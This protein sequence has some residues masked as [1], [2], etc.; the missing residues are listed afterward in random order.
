MML[1]RVG[2]AVFLVVIV[3]GVMFSGQVPGF[4]APA[5]RTITLYVAQSVSPTGIPNFVNP[6]AGCS[7]WGVGG[8]VF[9]GSGR[10]EPGLVVRV[11]GIVES[12]SV[13]TTVISGSSLAFGAGGFDLQLADHLPYAASLNLQLFDTSGRALSSPNRIPVYAACS[14]NLVVFNLRQRSFPW[15]AYMP[16]LRR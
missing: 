15:Q 8:Q 10:P 5:A 12:R 6:G 3:M 1:K 13:N 14:Q 11:S 16:L 7:W 9:N 4:A 2:L